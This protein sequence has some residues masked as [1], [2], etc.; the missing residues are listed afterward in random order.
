V[1]AQAVQGLVVGLRTDDTGAIE[2]VVSFLEEDPAPVARAAAAEALALFAFDPTVKAALVAALK[3]R[4]LQVARKA[5]HALLNVRE[6]P[7]QLALIDTLERVKGKDEGFVSELL[8]I[9]E[10]NV[11]S[12]PRDINPA[13]W[14]ALVQQEC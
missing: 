11:G 5:A 4:D 10:A 13:G 2:R 14:R 8:V 7:V 1:R 12:R 3:D 6:K 9:L